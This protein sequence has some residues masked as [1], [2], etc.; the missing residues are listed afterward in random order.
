MLPAATG[1]GDPARMGPAVTGVGA[2]SPTARPTP[3]VASMAPTQRDAGVIIPNN[4]DSPLGPLTD[5]ERE[6]LEAYRDLDDAD[7]VLAWSALLSELGR[8][9]G[10]DESNE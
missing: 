1:E 10:P 7:R 2:S 3:V 5:Q 4:D 9:P 6:L 8:R